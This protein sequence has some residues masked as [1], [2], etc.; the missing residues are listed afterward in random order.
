MADMTLDN[1]TNK[2]P[3]GTLDDG[4]GH[5]DNALSAA[6]PWQ[7]TDSIAGDPG[8]ASPA[9]TTLASY[10]LSLGGG[11]AAGSTG[12]PG[13]GADA[14]NGAPPS[15]ANAGAAAANG[16]APVSASVS[17]GAPVQNPNPGGGDALA[18]SGPPAAS[19]AAIST[20]ASY[21]ISGY[22]AWSGYFGTGP[23]NFDH[24]NLS[25]NISGLT[26]N[27]QHYAL[28]AMNLWCSVANLT[29]FTTTGTADITYNDSGSGQAVTSYTGVSGTT[30][31]GSV[32]DISTNWDVGPN[33]GSDY[34]YFMQTYIHETGHALGLGHQGPYNGSATYGVDN[35]YTNDTWRWSVMSYF[36]QSNYGSDS[37]D[38][39]LTPEMADIYAVQSIYGAQTTRSGDTTYGFN[40]TAGSYYDF[41]TYTGTP[42]FTIYDSGG[43]DTIDASGYSNNQ[44]IDLTPGDWSSIGGYTDNI[45][46]YLTTTIERAYGGS[47]NDAMYANGTGDALYGNAGNDTL[48]GGSGI[49]SLYGGD[50][51]DSIYGGAGNDFIDGGNGND[52]IDGGSGNDTIYGGAGNDTLISSGDDTIYGGDGND[53]IYAGLTSVFESLDGGAGV[54]TLD[55]TSWNT[56]TY[57]INLWTGSTNYPESFTNF[58]NLVS[59]G[60]D[61]QVSGTSADNNINTG[62][63]NDT[64]DG[65]LGNDT[66]NGGAGN[67]TL[68][69]GDGNDSLAGG[70]GNDVLDGGFGNDTL[71]GGAGTDTLS[72]SLDLGVTVS[73]ATTAA[74][75]TGGAGIDTV[76]NFENLTGSYFN[77]NLTGDAND[78]VIKG[79]GGSDTLSGGAGNDLLVA[80]DTNNTIVKPGSLHNS[81]LATA[82]DLFR[83]FGEQSADFIGNSTTVPHATVVATSSGDPEY[84]QFIAGAGATG[85]FDIDQTS[86]GQDTYI[87]L[88][89]HNG[90]VIASNDD[91]T[92]TLPNPDPGSSNPFDS[93]LNYTFTTTDFYY[94][95]VLRFP[96][97][98]PTSPGSTY[99]LNVSLTGSPI[100][101]ASGGSVLRGD[102][103][104]DTLFGGDGDDTLY[105]GT[106]ADTMYGGVG[107][108]S[109]YVDNTGD[110]VSEGSGAGTDTV[111]TSLLSYTLGANVENLT[112]VGV[113][114]FAGTGNEL[115]NIIT[116][117]AGNDTLRG[118]AGADTM[119]GGAGND[120]YYVDNA[121]DV[122][123]E[124]SGA[125]TD[126]VNTSLLSYMLGAN[127]ENLVFVGV[128]NFAGTGNALNNTVSGGAGNDTLR[129]GSGADTLIGGAGNDSY[130]VDNAGDVVTEASSAGTDT[131][132]TSLLS[133]TL[134]AN[135]EN[136]TFVGAG[137]FAGTGNALN[138]IITS[139]AGNDTLRGGN[140]ADT[141]IGGAGNDTYYVDNAGDVVTEASGAGT[142]TV[143]TSLLSYTLGA[144]VENLTFVGVGNFAGTGNAL[145]NIITGGAGADTLDG[146]LGGDMLVGLGGADSFRFDTALGVSNIDTVTD[147]SH[148]TDHILLS[149]ATFGLGSSGTLGAFSTGTTDTGSGSSAE[150][151]YNTSNGHV[152]YYNG[153]GTTTQFATLT[154]A[155]P[156]ISN[157]DFT[158]VA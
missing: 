148:L 78:N 154:G 34:N 76:S 7:A 11:D 142:D 90:N 35:I 79:G 95:E 36:S 121:G 63:G 129:G 38:Y 31:A 134:G 2:L 68:N 82:V 146:G 60:S 93:Y 23:R 14:P 98:V 48:F 29:Y 18:N 69:G 91:L 77:D 128:G 80:G 126:T 45:G 5:A 99:T 117:G 149:N 17:S 125:G 13:A 10:Y 137:N 57:V 106:G 51:N 39:V 157:A 132:N 49:D 89:D 111:N 64:V 46:I 87:K 130:Y 102:A 67:D 65:F 44:T 9:S 127:V 86:S 151:V 25:V 88:L 59:G 40:S 73:L 123:T 100:T 58:E 107:N 131:V 50:G 112:F 94:I 4:T 110:L 135:V 30:I 41:A 152:L 96:G 124:A 109:Y 33:T 3:N 84:Y 75:N 56:G 16:D 120:S 136:L 101:P 15:G 119:D 24:S 113:G 72:Y 19:F 104:N 155:P 52:Y 32:I 105:G 114:N 74:Q 8:A 61:D 28:T 115:N 122:V 145:N 138:N 43:Y 26:A 85:T 47:G 6:G 66:L 158:L 27:E 147:F 116:G 144:N 150:I 118:G 12:Q 70:D 54:D 143:N 53:Y 140:G 21:L 42:A 103:G 97:T 92:S 20:L 55:T 156:T 1:L 81:T 71:D 83:S 139:G 62:L 141:L 153:L 108:D 22:W 133:Y 37:Y